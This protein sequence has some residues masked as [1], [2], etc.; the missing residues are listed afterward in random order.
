MQ[1]NTYR[2]LETSLLSTPEPLLPS[3]PLKAQPQEIGTET[4]SE[5]EG[6]AEYSPRLD[7]QIVGPRI[8][9]PRRA[10]VVR[11]EVDEVDKR[12]DDAVESFLACDMARAD[13][14]EDLEPP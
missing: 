13:V 7:T 9:T 11:F 3:S 8:T 5:G 12:G 2:N 1:L 6:N 14:N 4:E 10:R